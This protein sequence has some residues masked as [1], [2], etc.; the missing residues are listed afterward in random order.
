MGAVAATDNAAALPTVG[1]W[2]EYTDYAE[3][4]R[5]VLTLANEAAQATDNSASQAS[6]TIAA[7]AGDV[8]GAFI[9]DSDQKNTATGATVLY[10]VGD[11]ASA[12]VVDA[13]DTLNITVTLSAASA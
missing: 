5:P 11:F 9:V 2:T 13:G 4:T 12:K 1:A 6:F 3:A 7:P 10:G 8:I